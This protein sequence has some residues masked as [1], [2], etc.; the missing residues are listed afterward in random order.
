MPQTANPAINKLVTEAGNLYSLPSVAI[1]VLQLTERP[2]VDV[3]QLKEAIQRDPALSAKLL[4]VVN[5]SLFGLSGRVAD[6]NQALALLGV[7][8]LKVLVL[9]FSLPDGLFAEMAGEPLRRYWTVA[10]TRAVCAK[11]LAKLFRGVSPDEAFLAGLLRDLGMLVMVQQLGEPYLRFLALANDAPEQLTALER[12]SLGF[13]HTQLTADLMRAW[14]LPDSLADAVDFAADDPLPL[15]EEGLRPVVMLA[16]RLC[17]LVLDRRLDALPELLE[18]GES[19]CGL[20]KEQLNAMLDPLQQQVDQLARAM[21][22]EL[23]SEVDLQK[24]ITE[25]HQQLSLASEQYVSDDLAGKSDDEIAEALLA[26]SHEVR[27]AMRE[28]LRGERPRGEALTRAEGAHAAKPKAAAP[29]QRADMSKTAR[30]RLETTLGKL[31]SSCRIERRELSVALLH[32]ARPPQTESN[33]AERELKQAL[34]AAQ[35]QLQLE[36]A[37]RLTL[38]EVRVAILMPGVDRREAV[39]YC[40]AAVEAA[41]LGDLISLKAGVGT[42]VQVPNRFEVDRLIDGAA[43]CLNGTQVAGSTSVKSIEVY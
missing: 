11:S 5:S 37:T 19:L 15:Q 14:R 9:G 27:L 2:T 7:E 13:D 33:A 39:A 35:E 3:Q 40:N 41:S 23:S 25:A 16:E 21:S 17:Q 42:V 10:L 31:A 38:D 18:A 29:K 20:T 4:R 34:A 24:V 8:P 1:E 43:G 6:L 32:V 36:D 30:T 28:F 12:Q 22:V 26:E